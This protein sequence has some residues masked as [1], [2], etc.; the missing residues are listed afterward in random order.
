VKKNNAESC[1]SSRLL[2]MLN[3]R[4]YFDHS[5]FLIGNRRIRTAASSITATAPLATP[6]EI[7][8]Q[9]A[10][11]RSCI[12]FASARRRRKI[13]TDGAESPENASSCP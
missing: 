11:I 5:P 3:R 12:N 8:F 2:L 6:G 10:A 7:S 1:H 4:R 13:R 9:A